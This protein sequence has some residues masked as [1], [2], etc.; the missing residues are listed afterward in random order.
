[1]AILNNLLA[2]AV[3]IY[4]LLFGNRPNLIGIFDGNIQITSAVAGYSV[5]MSSDVASHKIE[6]GN[7]I[8]DHSVYK[9]VDVTFT[10]VFAGQ[11][12]SAAYAALKKIYEDKRLVKIVTHSDNYTDML[13]YKLPYSSSAEKANTVTINVGFRQ[14]K[15]V[16]NSYVAGEQQVIKPK[17]LPATASKLKKTVEG[18]GKAG[19][20]AT[21]SQKSSAAKLLDFVKR[22]IQ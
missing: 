17:K 3:S 19:V 13:L 15:T 1:M 12:F 18:G 6:D 16:L 4:Q 7:L 2:G 9:P 22:K 5:D 8:S 10:M 14:I 11:D 21:V 20:V